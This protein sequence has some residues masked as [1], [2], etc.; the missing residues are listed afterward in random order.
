[1]SWQ[2]NTSEQLLQKVI[3]KRLQE[4]DQINV[5]KLR[6]ASKGSRG[7]LEGELLR[8][9]GVLEGELLR[10]WYVYIG[11]PQGVLEGELLRFW[12]VYIGDLLSGAVVIDSSSYEPNVP[13]FAVTWHRVR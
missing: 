10:F 5:N 8:F 1:M 13:L 11:V 2:E 3:Q 12:Y 4:F 6:S 7:V 9:W